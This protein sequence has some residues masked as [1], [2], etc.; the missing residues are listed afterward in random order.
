MKRTLFLVFVAFALALTG[1]GWAATF[2]VTPSSD[3]NC[4]DFDCTLLDALNIADKN[5]ENDTI[6]IQAGTYYT[7]GTVFKYTPATNENYSLTIVGAGAGT[8][9]L[10]GGSVSQVMQID[11]SG[12]TDDSNAHII[13][14]SV[15]FQ[16]GYSIG[17]AGGLYVETISADISVENSEFDGN[18]ANW[19]GGG[20]YA[21]SSSGSI[22]YKNNSFSGNSADYGGGAY[23]ENRTGAITITGNTFSGNSTTNNEG[24]GAYAYS[25]SGTI[26]L[27]NN[28][29]NGNSANWEGGGACVYPSR[30]NV[31]LTNN[32]F[33]GNSSANYGGGAYV[34][35][36]TTGTLTLT[37]NSLRGN[38]AVSG[39][40]LYIAMY[41]DSATV[42]I[43]NNIIW[44]NTA[45]TA[46][47]DL[48]VDDDGDGNATATAVNLFYNVFSTF[49]INVGGGTLSQGNNIDRDPVLTVDF[50]LTASSPAID[51]GDNNAPGLP[52]TDFDG[53][54]RRIN[55]PTVPDTGNGT[56]PIV[57][58]GADEFQP[59]GMFYLIPN[60]RGGGAVIYLE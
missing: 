20:V 27:T 23:A 37:N 46:G 48:Y 57:D 60:K 11:I 55:D 54:D 52:T 39:G 4:S 10:D 19:E 29:F 31:I 58:I 40:G 59:E 49:A 8:T 41:E 25:S 38:S 6:N 24:G 36:G 28:N 47:G 9:T 45:T 18:S 16:Q 43:Y 21:Y 14:K 50:H 56:A 13:I 32:T 44:G 3:N 17:Y 33:S 22:T 51:A 15:T 30:G 34:H 26:T 42:N 53:D 12:L 35:S 7:S 5:G 1:N 2:T